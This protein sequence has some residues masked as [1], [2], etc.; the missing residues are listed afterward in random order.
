MAEMDYG[1]VGAGAAS[2]AAAGTMIMPGWGTA[3]GAVVGAGLSIYG[4]SKQQES[5]KA[6]NEAQKKQIEL[7][8]KVEAQKRQAMELDARRKSLENIR[9]IQRMRAL[10]LTNAT[11]QGAAQG[12]GLQGGYGQISGQGGWNA[13]GINQNLQIGENIFDINAQIS[14]QKIAM[15]NA[16]MLQQ[17][18]AA[19][20]SAG[21]SVM[22][23][24]G[25]LG[26]LTG[27]YT[28]KSP[29]SG[30]TNSGPSAFGSSQ[31]MY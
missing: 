22:G 15:A 7:E 16:G 2:G 27:P 31:A 1:S 18:G 26:K 4:A 8:Q 19:F 28:E 3:I 20:S 21:S 11:S 29:Y 12:S 6:Y 5:S 13:L 24:A 9:Q 17:Q 10:A 14:Q 23:A 25:T 30:S